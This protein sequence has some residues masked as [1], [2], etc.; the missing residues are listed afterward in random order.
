MGIFF[1]LFSNK[2]IYYCFFQVGLDNFIFSAKNRNYCAFF[3]CVCVN[4]RIYTI[5]NKRKGEEGN[6]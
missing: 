6:V 3:D 4:I 5:R 1:F 2:K